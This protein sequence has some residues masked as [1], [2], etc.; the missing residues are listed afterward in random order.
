MAGR[1]ILQLLS[2][3]FQAD[4]RR[5]GRQQRRLLNRHF[6]ITPPRRPERRYPC[7]ILAVT[8][9]LHT[10]ACLCLPGS[11]HIRPVSTGPWEIHTEPPVWGEAVKRAGD[12]LPNALRFGQVCVSVCMYVCM[13]AV[14]TW[15]NSLNFCIRSITGKKKIFIDWFFSLSP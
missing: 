5:G 4:A 10:V 11:C 14:E 8:F 6:F 3:A 12:M 1:G 15:V 9:L 2:S 13:L 7:C